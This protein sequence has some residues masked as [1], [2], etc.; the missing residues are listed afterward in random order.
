M[1]NEHPAS[2][3]VFYGRMI[4][5]LGL[6]ALAVQLKLFDVLLCETDDE[7]SFVRFIEQMND[8]AL[9]IRKRNQLPPLLEF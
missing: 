3:Q 9:T 4:Y 1:F 8:I 2:T 6:N 7:Y 5:M